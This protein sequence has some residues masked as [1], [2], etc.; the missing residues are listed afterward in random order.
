MSPAAVKEIVAPQAS[1]PV[2]A[3]VGRSCLTQTA[4]ADIPRRV[5]LAANIAEARSAWRAIR[6]GFVLR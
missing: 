3:R 4:N 6:S 5:V 2:T 1:S